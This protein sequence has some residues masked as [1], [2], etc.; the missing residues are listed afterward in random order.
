MSPATSGL[1]T[2]KSDEHVRSATKYEV[3]RTY[4]IKNRESSQI[5]KASTNAPSV[6]CLGVSFF[7]FKQFQNG[8]GRLV[9]DLHTR[10]A[11]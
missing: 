3:L 7:L 10:I 6:V 8:K 5:A 1:S 4:G 2:A 9:C 11:A